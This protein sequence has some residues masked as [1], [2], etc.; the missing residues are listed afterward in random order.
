MPLL[1]Q[2]LQRIEFVELSDLRDRTDAADERFLQ[3]NRLR[4]GHDI[5]RGHIDLHQ[6]PPDL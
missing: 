2:D 4:C 5:Q 3:Q 6:L 1:L